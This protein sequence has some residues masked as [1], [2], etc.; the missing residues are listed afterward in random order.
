MM[1]CSG[2]N[3]LRVRLVLIVGVSVPSSAAIGVEA[4]EDSDEERLRG[5]VVI[6]TVREGCS[7]KTRLFV[8][9]TSSVTILREST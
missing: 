8:T 4:I 6:V 3:L 1:S 5:I 2:L 9:H 7:I